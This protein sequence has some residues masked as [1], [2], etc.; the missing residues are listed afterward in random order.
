M[1]SNTG[2]AGLSGSLQKKQTTT[3]TLFKYSRN[4]KPI[5]LKKLRESRAEEV[6]ANTLSSYCEQVRE[7]LKSRQR[8]GEC[9]S[10][11]L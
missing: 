10:T 7:S 4:Y 1:V 5:N 8:K 11:C 3:K 9:A 6:T 2:A